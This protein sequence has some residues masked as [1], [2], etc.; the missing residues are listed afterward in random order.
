MTAS[1]VEFI[2]GLVCFVAIIALFGFIFKCIDVRIRVDIRSNHA[3][4]QNVNQKVNAK[5]LIT[6][7]DKLTGFYDKMFMDAGSAGVYGGVDGTILPSYLL[8]LFEIVKK[9][10]EQDGNTENGLPSYC[11]IDFGSGL[12]FAML[13]YFAYFM[14]LNMKGVENQRFRYLQSMQLHER[15]LQEDNDDINSIVLKC[16]IHMNTSMQDAFNYIK[17]PI[18]LVYMFCCGWNKDDKVAVVKWMSESRY[19]ANIKY[20]ITDIRL[21][22]ERY[23]K[24]SGALFL[25]IL[26]YY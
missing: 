24:F 17:T 6:M 8:P 18:R 22:V 13:C 1:V 19:A 2:S 26:I 12:S 11:G 20:F 5:D 10:L 7:F 21:Y 25:I 15:L 9:D 3:Q 23:N 14:N 16:D 4:H